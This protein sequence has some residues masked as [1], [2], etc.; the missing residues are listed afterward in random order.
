MTVSPAN[1]SIDPAPGED[2]PAS[3]RPL[4]RFCAPPRRARLAHCLQC[5]R[6]AGR[7]V[8]APTSIEGV[9]V[10]GDPVGE[11]VVGGFGVDVFAAV[12]IGPPQL[13]G[14]LTGRCPPGEV[15]Q[16]ERCC[17]SYPRPARRSPS[18]RPRLP[19]PAGPPTAAGRGGQAVRA[20]PILAQG[21]DWPGSSPG[22][23]S[24]GPA[25]EAERRDW[26]FKDPTWTGS[27]RQPPGCHRLMQGYLATC[28]ALGELAELEAFR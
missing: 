2:Q 5:R 27:G 14:L 4:P 13:V 17:G 3:R 26:R 24:G 23:P 15:N 8:Q 11:E 20:G 25:V 22:S 16:Y 6:A 21:R 9:A 18:A 10:P 1:R 19:R 28:Q 7:S 12:G